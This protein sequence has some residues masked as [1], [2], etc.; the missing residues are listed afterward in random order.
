MNARRPT[1][2]RSATLGRAPPKVHRAPT[3]IEIGIVAAALGALL[4]KADPSLTIDLEP[5]LAEVPSAWF[6]AVADNIYRFSPVRANVEDLKRFHGTN[7]RIATANYV[8]LI[9][10]YHQLLLNSARP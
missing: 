1:S 2:T 9:Q 7:E 10:F 5:V 3:P 8:E 6:D 4:R